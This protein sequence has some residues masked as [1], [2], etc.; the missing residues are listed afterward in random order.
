MEL[1]SF[2]KLHAVALRKQS[3]TTNN[4]QWPWERGGRRDERTD[5]SEAKNRIEADNAMNE[6]ISNTISV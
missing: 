6:T 3:S 4:E 2:D 1:Y 5:N